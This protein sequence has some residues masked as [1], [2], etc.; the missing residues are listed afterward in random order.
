MSFLR[1]TSS[2]GKLDK[3][4]QWIFMRDIEIRN[5]PLFPFN[6][7]CKFSAV[8]LNFR[9]KCTPWSNW[10][11]VNETR[12]FCAFMPRNLSGIVTFH[13]L[14]FVKRK[15]YIFDSNTFH[16]L[17]FKKSNIYTINF[18]WVILQNINDVFC[19]TLM[20]TWNQSFIKQK[21]N[22]WLDR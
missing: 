17:P 2:F 6:F 11:F 18:V 9:R 16:K 22:K 20:T 14:C 13:Y 12:Y 21:R 15:E 5:F 3:K 8:K 4:S 19:W 10:V 7:D 1:Q